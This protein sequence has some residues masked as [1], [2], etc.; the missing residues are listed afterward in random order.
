MSPSSW[1]HRPQEA[2]PREMRWSGLALS[3]LLLAWGATWRVRGDAANL[4]AI[5]GRSPDGAVILGFWHNRMLMMAY[6]HR[7]QGITVMRSSS[8]DGRLIAAVLGRLGLGSVAGSSSRGGAAG[9]RRIVQLA[10]SGGDTA[11]TVDGPRGPRGRVKEG[12]LQIAALS[13]API[14][15]SAVA[16]PRVKYFGS[17]DRTMLPLPFTRLVVRY[18]EP[19]FVPRDADRQALAALRVELEARI[20]ELSDGLDEECGLV[21]IPAG[22]VEGEG[23]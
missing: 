4:A 16:A 22:P 18:G 17:W 6:T 12:I 20:G 23:G 1:T 3:L 2:D 5:R 8:R 9:L 10:R 19:L 7:G 15:P 11:I 21:P 14:V 13:G